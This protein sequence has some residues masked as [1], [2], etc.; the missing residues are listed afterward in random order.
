MREVK[1]PKWLP[2]RQGDA[3]VLFP[4]VTILAC[5]DT[6]GLWAVLTVAA[7]LVGWW[8]WAG[9]GPRLELTS[10]QIIS[11]ASVGWITNTEPVWGLVIAVLWALAMRQEW[12]RRQNPPQAVVISVERYPY[13]K[14]SNN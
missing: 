11:A 12:T 13:P 1:R 8:K 10:F 7:M 9:W 4:T 5:L 6:H 2:K 14:P 3:G